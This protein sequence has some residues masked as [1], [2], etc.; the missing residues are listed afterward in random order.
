MTEDCRMFTVACVEAERREERAER[1]KR[2]AAKV[3]ANARKDSVTDGHEL[4]TKKKAQ[5]PKKKNVRQKH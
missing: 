3:K 4:P 5:K 2:E 1:E